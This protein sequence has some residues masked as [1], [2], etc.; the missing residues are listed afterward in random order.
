MLPVASDILR[1]IT[2]HYRGDVLAIYAKRVEGLRLLQKEFERTGGY[3]A[4]SYA[5][6]KPVD[7]EMYKLALLLS[8]ICTNH[9][10]EILKELERFLHESRGGTRRLLSIG[11]GTGYELK[12]AWEALPGWI[13]EAFDNAEESLSYAKDLLGFFKCGPM[14]LRTEYFPLETIDGHDQY[15]G[16]FGKIVAC[17]LLEHLENPV[18]ALKNLREVLHEK[19]QIFLTMA[20]NIAQEDHVFLYGS[21]QQA[22]E[23][24]LE[25]GYRIVRDALSPAVAL[26][27][28]EGKREKIFRKGNYICIAERN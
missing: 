1:F 21:P 9:R 2:H 23:Q 11:Y 5:E 20:I 7:D 17:E 13:I 19:G 14:T 25:C 3:S 16:A 26:P 12:L 4:R 28:E 6:V 27:F 22:R 10:F 15:R 24:V 18:D 8:F